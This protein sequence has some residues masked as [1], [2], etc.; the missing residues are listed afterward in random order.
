MKRDDPF[1][2]VIEMAVADTF[3]AS[4]EMIRPMFRTLALDLWRRWNEHYAGKRVPKGSRNRIASR[5]DRIRDMAR[6]GTS[7]DQLAH[8]F[9]LTPGA[10]RRIIKTGDE[11]A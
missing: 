7:P 11:S 6:G 10:V 8:D 9:H 1:D 5:N 2:R 3:T 4:A